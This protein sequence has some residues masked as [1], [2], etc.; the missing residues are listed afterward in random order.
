[1]PSFWKWQFFNLYAKLQFYPRHV[2]LQNN[3]FFK[4]F[5]FPNL[6]PYILNLLW[7]YKCFSMQ[8]Y[9]R[10]KLI[11]IFLEETM[12]IDSINDIAKKCADFSNF[13]FVCTPTPVVLSG[14]FVS[15]GFLVVY[16]LHPLTEKTP[17]NGSYLADFYVVTTSWPK[18][19]NL[20]SWKFYK[21]IDIETNRHH[22][23]SF[24]YQL[25]LKIA[26]VYQWTP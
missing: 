15:F 13:V 9:F 2:R 10:Y 25:I 11:I 8:K 6:Y 26:L 3:F 20:K 18:H 1:M 5:L 22:S 4:N 19:Y 12:Q 7:T 16:T 14:Q 24:W 23:L 17:L 21:V